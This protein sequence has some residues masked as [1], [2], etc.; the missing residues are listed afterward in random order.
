MIAF[1]VLKSLAIEKYGLYPASFD[2]PFV[3]A[4]EPGPN[5]VVGVNGSGKTT[6]V[7]MALRCLTGPY[8]L[9]SSS[10]ESEF[11]QVRPRARH[12][13][14]PERQ[15]F[16][17]RVADGARDGLATLS[18]TLGKKTVEITRTLADLGLK[19]LIVS[20]KKIDCTPTGNDQNEEEVYQEKIAALFGV[21]TFFD[22][23]IILRFLVF[24]LED[25]RALVWDPTAQ[26]QIFRVLLLPPDRAGEYAT[27]Q[28]AI[29]SADS[30][31]RNT[32]N[33]IFRYENE[34][35]IAAKQTKVISGVEAQRRVKSAEALAVR[36]RLE[37]AARAR[38][39]ADDARRA[40]RLDRLK[41]AE[42]RDSS[43]R[44]LERIKMEALR[45]WLGPS[46]DTVRYVVGHLLADRRCLV[47]N[48]D[49]APSA[50]TIED[51]LRNGL[52]PLCGSAH[53]N[54]EDVV[55]FADA[56]RIRIQRLEA[57]IT[58]ADKQIAD[59]EARIAEAIGASTPPTT[60]ILILKPTASR[61]TGKCSNSLRS[62]RRTAQRQQRAT[63]TLR[64]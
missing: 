46:K 42:N 31:V 15:V 10:S 25:R 33:Q 32:K 35:K 20:S 27:A 22:V 45:H 1:P 24:M 9:P 52:C 50:E 21:G 28:Q 7:M 26:R 62:C 56:H 19:E 14:K 40:A 39:D 61:S 13:S 51:R 16:S 63:R 44:E 49:P 6:L 4:F 38:V 47:C 48:T 53:Q 17:R 30:A 5:L 3:P 55:P 8:D 23:L 36:E 34:L 60:S 57:K 64:H 54:N 59:A 43:V 29:I 37:A 12:L 58:L 2:G 11:G 41:V 18:F